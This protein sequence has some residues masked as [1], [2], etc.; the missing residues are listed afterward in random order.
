MQTSIKYFPGRGGVADVDVGE[1]VLRSQNIERAASA[2]A[3]IEPPQQRQL[4]NPEQPLA[5]VLS[6][7]NVKKKKRMQH[8]CWKQKFDL[9]TAIYKRCGNGLP[10]SAQE[11]RDAATRRPDAPTIMEAAKLAKISPYRTAQSILRRY[12]RDGY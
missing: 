4:P 5:R 1:G 10:T 8:T 7:S 11:R 2:I 3:A 9:I 6:A 12:V